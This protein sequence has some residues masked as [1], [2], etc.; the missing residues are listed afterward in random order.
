MIGSPPTPMAILCPMPRLV[1]KLAISVVMP[2]LRERIA[3][4]PGL[5]E[6]RTLSTRPPIVPIFAMPG[7]ISPS[8]FGP[9]TVQ[10]AASG[11]TQEPCR[12][13]ARNSF[14][15]DKQQL[16]AVRNRFSRRIQYAWR[17]NRD[18]AGTARVLLLRFCD[19][20]VDGTP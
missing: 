9:M 16:D 14:G 10:P 15:H 6:R 20:V 2:P 17:G 12:I 19:C 1:R 4:R 3:T 11:Q 13:Q 18:D 8:V 7:R 5:N